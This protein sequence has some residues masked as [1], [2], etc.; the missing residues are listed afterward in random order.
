MKK[1]TNKILL[2]VLSVLLMLQFVPISR[3]SALSTPKDIIY[4]GDNPIAKNIGR[5][6][7]KFLFNN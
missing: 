7:R 1:F 4:P 6:N 5:T 2:V 3:L